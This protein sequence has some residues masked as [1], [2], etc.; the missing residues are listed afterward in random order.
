M[1]VAEMLIVPTPNLL[2]VKIIMGKHEAWVGTAKEVQERMKG[3]IN[4][5]YLRENLSS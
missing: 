2:N 1:L 4:G 5:R 3:I